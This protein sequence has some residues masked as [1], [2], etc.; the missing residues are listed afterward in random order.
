VYGSVAA[1]LKCCT[2]DATG[3]DC[4]ENL[5]RAER[6]SHRDERGASQSQRHGKEETG[7][8][9]SSALRLL[10]HTGQSRTGRERDSLTQ[11]GCE[12]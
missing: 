1:R 8:K 6:A 12:Y 5:V 9:S 7:H 3:T 4:T 2:P 11:V 10:P